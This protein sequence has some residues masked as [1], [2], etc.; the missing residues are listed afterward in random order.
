M[1]EDRLTQILREALEAGRLAAFFD[2]TPAKKK[3]PAAT[4]PPAKETRSDEWHH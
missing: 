3:E 1:A 4:S 2:R